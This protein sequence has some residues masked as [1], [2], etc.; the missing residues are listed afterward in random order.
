MPAGELFPAPGALAEKSPAPEIILPENHQGPTAWSCGIETRANSIVAGRLATRRGSRR[1]LFAILQRFFRN[2]RR[3]VEGP[4]NAASSESSALDAWPV[5]GSVA[6]WRLGEGKFE[7]AGGVGGPLAS[8][9]SSLWRGDVWRT[10]ETS[11]SA[12][13]R[14]LALERNQAKITANNRTFASKRD[15]RGLETGVL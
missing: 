13:R 7:A 4:A 5:G 11:L 10:T 6:S 1:A 14:T 15:R 2:H 9:A 8:P 12:N 3:S